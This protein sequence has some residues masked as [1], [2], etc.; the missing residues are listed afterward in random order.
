MPRQLALPLGG[1]LGGTG[2][3]E[4]EEEVIRE[5]DS[6]CRSQRQACYMGIA[7]P[8]FPGGMKKF[9]VL[10]TQRESGTYQGSVLTREF[11]L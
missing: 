8:I 11:G 4:Q 2:S 3:R 6:G 5:K 1:W 7:C 10:D 9:K